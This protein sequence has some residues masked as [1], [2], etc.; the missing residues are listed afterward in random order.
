M[1]D[2]SNTQK[3]IDQYLADGFYYMYGDGEMI[4]WDLAYRN[5]R[6]AADFGS[7]VACYHLGH[8]FFTEAGAHWNLEEAKRW[9]EEAYRRGYEAGRSRAWQVSELMKES[10]D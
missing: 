5:L 4:D 10:E 9:F 1:T 2:K 3:S 8:L 7:A 6:K